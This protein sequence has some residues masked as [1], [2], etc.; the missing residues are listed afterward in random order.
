MTLNT[1]TCCGQR[2]DLTHP[3]DVAVCCKCGQWYLFG[4]AYLTLA[5][6][7]AEARAPMSLED[8]CAAFARAEERMACS[9]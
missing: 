5:G 3:G 6:A 4:G 7:A 9:T 8:V 1:L 2:V